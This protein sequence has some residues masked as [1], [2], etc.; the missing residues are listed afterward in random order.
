M[1]RALS[2]RP[3]GLT[4]GAGDCV[5]YLT[6]AVRVLQPIIGGA[7]DTATAPGVNSKLRINIAKAGEGVDKIKR[8]AEA[9]LSSGIT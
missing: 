8:G 2:N 4:S 3:D 7:N 1:A 9:P 6:C 5:T